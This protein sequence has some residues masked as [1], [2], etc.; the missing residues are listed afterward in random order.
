[1]STIS[2]LEEI[3]LDRL[4]GE[5]SDQIAMRE[6]M[7]FLYDE[8]L[9]KS[10]PVILEIGVHSGQS[11]VSFLRALQHHE[12]G[13]LY[14]IDI[15]YPLDPIYKLR[16]LGKWRFLLLASQEVSKVAENVE[17]LLDIL[18]VDGGMLERK[19]DLYAYGSWVKAGGLILFHDIDR[20]GML[21]IFTEYVSYR[22]RDAV[23]FSFQGNLG[24]I[25][26]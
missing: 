3:W 12:K 14:S 23:T 18:L 6:H 15:N 4:Q 9:I 8:T 7:Q 21:E 5:R 13:V 19:H 26:L 2:Y 24:V 17:Y 25:R 20:D 22:G 10:D 11:T 16:G 1:M